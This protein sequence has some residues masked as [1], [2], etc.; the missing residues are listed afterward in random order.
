MRT[1]PELMENLSMLLGYRLEE[2]H[3]VLFG[4]IILESVMENGPN[5]ISVMDRLSGTERA[6]DDRDVKKWYHCHP[7]RWNEI[8]R[9]YREGGS[10]WER[11]V[12]VEGH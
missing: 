10:Y 3:A 11:M 1:N 5:R 7:D 6:I 2:E 12:G 8:Q 9:P 4:E